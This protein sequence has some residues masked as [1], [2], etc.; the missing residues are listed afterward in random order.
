MRGSKE[1][2]GDK[3]F[4]RETRNVCERKSVKTRS[5]DWAS[6]EVC[7]CVCRHECTTRAPSLSFARQACPAAPSTRNHV[8]AFIVIV[9]VPFG[10]ARERAG[11]SG[12]GARRPVS[13]TNIKF[14]LDECS[15]L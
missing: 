13:V 2:A 1:C 9:V 7:V 14:I 10:A 6:E 3:V 8:T 11:R 5:L 4:R 12:A 15:D